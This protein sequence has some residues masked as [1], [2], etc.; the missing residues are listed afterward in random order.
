MGDYC[1]NEH[2]LSSRKYQPTSPYL[3]NSLLKLD[4]FQVGSLQRE[5]HLAQTTRKTGPPPELIFLR[6]SS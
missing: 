3:T 1:F 2:Y 6:A 5:R 4:G